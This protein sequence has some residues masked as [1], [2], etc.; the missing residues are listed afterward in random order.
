MP[1]PTQAAQSCCWGLTAEWTGDVLP[2]SDRL[3]AQALSFTATVTESV[4]KDVN[5]DT[6]SLQVTQGTCYG[7]GCLAAVLFPHLSAEK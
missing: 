7:W 2:H 1:K 3:P 5:K 6:C 4:T